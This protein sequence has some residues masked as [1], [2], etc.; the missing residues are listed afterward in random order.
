MGIIACLIFGVLAAWITRSVL[1]N[2]GTGGAVAVLV[3]GI[4]GGL[5]GLIG[6]AFGFG[7]IAHFNLFN[8]F[9]S[10][11]A[12]AIITGLWAKLQPQTIKTGRSLEA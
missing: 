12:A 3:I 5:L 1:I 4:L 9:F 10:I 2:A 6:V 11:L 7:D 8:V